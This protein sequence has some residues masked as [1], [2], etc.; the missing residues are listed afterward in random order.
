MDNQEIRAKARALY[1]KYFAAVFL[2]GLC[3]DNVQSFLLDVFEAYL[4]ELS[5]VL[6]LPIQLLLIPLTVGGIGCIEPLWTSEQVRFERL[7]AF[8]APVSRFG[9]SILLGIIPILA[10]LLTLVPGMLLAALRGYILIFLL[11]MIATL[12]FFMRLVMAAMLFAS[13]RYTKALDAFTASYQK[14]RGR[15]FDLLA[16]TVI[17]LLPQVIITKLLQALSEQNNGLWI[18]TA[19]ELAFTLLYVPYST[20]ATQGWVLEQI[21][22]S[23]QPQESENKPNQRPFLPDMKKEV[24][25]SSGEF[26]KR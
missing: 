10:G 18:F 13:G 7:F 14:M 24:E 21:K 22:D 16:M 6:Y 4:G 11:L 5:M 15:L 1:G 25:P 8:Y 2:I 19:L 17:I 12:W 23:E 3:S 9:Q 20:L 26:G